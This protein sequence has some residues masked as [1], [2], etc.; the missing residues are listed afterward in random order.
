MLDQRLEFLVK[1]LRVLGLGIDDHFVHIHGVVVREGRVAR[2][3]FVNQDP[4]G[5]PVDGLGVAFVK[6]N[7]WR[8]VLGGSANGVGAFLNHLGK[9]VVY[10]LQVAVVRNHNIFRLQVSVNDVLAVHVLEHTR[11]LRTIKSKGCLRQT[12]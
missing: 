10:E 3:H 6:Q 1:T 12:Y 8:D 2:V 7:L 9:P 5:P 11:N 4:E